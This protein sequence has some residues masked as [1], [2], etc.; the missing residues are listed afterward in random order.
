MIG[1]HFPEILAAYSHIHEDDIEE[2]KA[3]ATQG[4]PSKEEENRLN[5]DSEVSDHSK[6]PGKR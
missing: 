3:T 4:T 1:L 6:D 2:G 5:I